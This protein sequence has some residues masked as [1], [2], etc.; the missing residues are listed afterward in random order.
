MI[1]I[2]ELINP[3][4]A[5]IFK[6]IIALPT[7]I[8]EYQEKL[9]KHFANQF[10]ELEK[11]YKGAYTQSRN[12]IADG[13]YDNHRNGILQQYGSMDAYWEHLQNK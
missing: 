13:D 9:Q 1:G 6:A 2:L 4:L 12:E 7:T 8:A 3:E 10:E 11:D 5:E